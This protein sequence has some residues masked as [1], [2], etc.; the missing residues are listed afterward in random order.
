MSVE[1]N[2]LKEQELSLPPIRL[3][4]NG[5]AEYKKV[6]D[7]VFISGLG[8]LND[9]GKL[10]Y[11]G[12]VGAEYTVEEGY[13]A[14]RLAGL[15]VLQRIKDAAG[16]LDRVDFVVKSVV[17]VSAPQGFGD[18]YKVADGFSDVLTEV[19]GER[20]LHARNAVGASTLNGNAPVICDAIVKLRD[21]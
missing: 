9:E 12:R 18:I 3:T 11:T 13:K 2:R 17:C 20:G 5:V 14:A 4:N 8:P 19:L 21:I 15:N 1:L 7:L 10:A 6:G 16:G